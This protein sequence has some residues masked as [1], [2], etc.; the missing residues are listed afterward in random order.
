[1]PTGIQQVGARF[2]ARASQFASAVPQ[3]LWPS[4]FDFSQKHEKIADGIWQNV[5]T[6]HSRFPAV[7][8]LTVLPLL[9]TGEMSV[10]GQNFSGK[11][12]KAG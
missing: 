12:M 11:R 2:R 7:L 5:R 1:L 8:N 9:K 10:E 4:S 3:A 6:G